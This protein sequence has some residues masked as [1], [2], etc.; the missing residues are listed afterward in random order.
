MHVRYPN[1]ENLDFQL[2]MW[3][4]FFIKACEYSAVL[5]MPKRKSLIID[6]C[7]SKKRRKKANSS[8]KNLSLPKADSYVM[9]QKIA[10]F[11]NEIFYFAF[12]YVGSLT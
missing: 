6:W 5:C 9:C 7:I 2:L 10:H 4:K 11:F 12:Y 3:W 8:W 1:S